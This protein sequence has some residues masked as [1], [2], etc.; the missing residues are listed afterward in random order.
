M[1]TSALVFSML[2][3]MPKID[4][5]VTKKG[6]VVEDHFGVKIA[7]PYRWLEDANSEETKSWVTAQNAVTFDYLRSIPEWASVRRRLEELYTYERFGVPEIVGSSLVYT[8][9]TGTQNQSVYMISDRDGKNP[10]EL[11]DPNTL[12]KD[13]TVAVGSVAFSPDGKLMAYALSTGGSDWQE[14]HVRDVVTGKDLT[15]VVPWSKFSGA[16]WSHDSKGFYY[17]AYDAPTGNTALQAANYFQKV[18]FHKIGTPASSDQLIYQDKDHKEWGF[19]AF[20][21]EDGRFIVISQSEG[22]RPEN[23]IYVKDKQSKEGFVP[24]LNDF[25]ASYSVVANDGPVFYI[26]TDKDAPKQRVITVDVTKAGTANWK[27]VVPEASE[28]LGGVSILGKTIFAS[29]LKDAHSVVRRF[30][31]QGKAL[32]EV[33]LPGL[34]TSGGFGGRRKDKETFFSFV[35]YTTPGTVYR[36][37][38]ASGKVSEFTRPSLRFNPDDFE[39]KQVFYVSKDGTKVPMFVTYKKG[40]KLD[41]TNPTLLTG[42]GGFNIAITPGFRVRALQWMELGGVFAEANLRG[43]SEYGKTWYDAGRL[44]NKQNV[45]DDFIAAAEYLIR[46][47]YTSTPKLAIEGGSNGGLLVGAVETQR[48]DLFGACLPHV[49]VLDMLRFHKF[50]IGYAWKSDYGDPDTEA[51]FQTL[52]K[53]SPLHN[54][55]PGT[56]YPPTLIF[57][58]DHDDRVVPAHS[59]KFAATM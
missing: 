40:L 46:E 45:F 57:T 8:H 20:E 2:A 4:P 6:E 15:D 34:G 23:R 30:D 36:M 44:K 47:K 11:L 43:G 17:S 7:D 31:L 35:S 19:G 28:T 18:Y 39:T 48:P 25:D 51:D 24:V 29:Y 58:G 56:A 27:T 21:T 32:G 3:S 38:V 37:D 59:F 53:Y 26:Q 55:K 50:T 54:V 14:W 49:G 1:L 13:G 10:R 9:N 41:G 33:S 22:T 12:S 42:Y 5:P 16:S 52:L